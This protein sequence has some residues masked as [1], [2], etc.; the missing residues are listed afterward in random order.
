MPKPEVRSELEKTLK[1]IAILGL[2]GKK[3][4]DQ[5]RLLDK[6]GFSYSEIAVLLGSTPKAISVRLAELRRATKDEK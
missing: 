3:Q 4:K 5:V 1:L 2:E 6:A